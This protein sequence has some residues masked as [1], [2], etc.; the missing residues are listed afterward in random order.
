MLGEKRG[1]SHMYLAIFK[2]IVWICLM[3]VFEISRSKKRLVQKVPQ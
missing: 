2:A 3:E 1:F